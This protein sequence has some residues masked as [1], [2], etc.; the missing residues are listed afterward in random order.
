MV[1]KVG[2]KWVAYGPGGKAVGSFNLKGQA[3]FAAQ[4]ASS[5]FFS[6]KVKIKNNT[7]GTE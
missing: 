2:N 4:K 6:E 1:K 7:Q 3:T 5:E